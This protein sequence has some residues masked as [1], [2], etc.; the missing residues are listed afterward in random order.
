MITLKQLNWG[1]VLPICLQDR[2]EFW[3]EFLQNYFEQPT[4]KTSF[5]LK[6]AFEGSPIK[7]NSSTGY[8]K[9]QND[10]NN[11]NSRLLCTLPFCENGNLADIEYVGHFQSEELA[12]NG[13]SKTV[14]VFCL[15]VLISANQ[16]LNQAPLLL[17][18]LG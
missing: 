1:L 15:N 17:V 13:K 4:Y 2:S 5:S 18:R 12:V 3:N 14:K 8:I 6:L 7:H 10:F 16:E 11:K 9:C